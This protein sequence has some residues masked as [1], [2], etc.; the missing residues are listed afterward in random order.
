MSL[1]AQLFRAVRTPLLIAC[2]L[3]LAMGCKK[4]EESNDKCESRCVADY[5]EEVEDCDR[6]TTECLANCAGPEDVDCTWDCEDYQDECTFGFILCAN[7][8]P[9]AKDVSSCLQ[10]CRDGESIDQQCALDCNDEYLD[11]A[12]GDSSTACGFTCQSLAY[13]CNAECEDLSYS[14]DEFVTCRD[15]C[16]DQVVG[17]LDDC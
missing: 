7:S 2:A 9:C 15:G 3:T 4:K 17:C 12:G 8:C 10:G 1:I 13:S 6:Q 14:S 11:C 16:T 5:A